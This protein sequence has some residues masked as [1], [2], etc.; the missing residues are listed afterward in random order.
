MTICPPPAISIRQRWRMFDD[1]RGAVSLSLSTPDRTS[2]MLHLPSNLPATGTGGDSPPQ[3]NRNFFFWL[4]PAAS[5]GFRLP[6]LPIAVYY[7]GIAAPKGYR[8]MTHEVSITVRRRSV[9]GGMR[10]PA[11]PRTHTTHRA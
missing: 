8:G 6:S 10:Y 4:S 3:N 5:H 2:V 7:P 1:A 9:S 11:P